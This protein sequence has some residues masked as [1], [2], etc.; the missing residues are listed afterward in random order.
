MFASSS[1]FDVSASRDGLA[2]LYRFDR[3][4]RSARFKRFD[5]F[6]RFASANGLARFDRFDA[7]ARAGRILDALTVSAS[8]DVVGGIRAIINA[9]A[10][11]AATNAGETSAENLSVGRLR[12]GERA[13]R[14]KRVTGNG[15]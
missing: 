11:A 4:T 9:L 5:R 6:A 13:K 3:L 1:R 2:R 14:D 12:S 10:N 8:V 15:V 7:S